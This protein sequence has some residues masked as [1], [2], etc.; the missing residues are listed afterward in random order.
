MGAFLG[1]V[2]SLEFLC[3]WEWGGGAF[4]WQDLSG[5]MEDHLQDENI[6][7]PQEQRLGSSY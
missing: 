2:E 7:S 3:F 6:L 4:L 5:N 1:E